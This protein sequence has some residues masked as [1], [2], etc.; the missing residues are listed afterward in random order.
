MHKRKALRAILHLIPGNAAATQRLRII[1]AL[2][3]LGTCTTP[4]LTRW[5]DC[6]RVGARIAEMRAEGVPIVT[7][8]RTD[9][10]EAGEPHRFAMYALAPSPAD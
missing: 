1:T 4:E 5:L 6:P 3:T 7:H 10:T 9:T 8:W 2:Q